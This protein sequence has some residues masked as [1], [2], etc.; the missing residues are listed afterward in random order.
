[1]LEG[2]RRNMHIEEVGPAEDIQSQTIGN[3]LYVSF[4]WGDVWESVHHIEATKKTGGG[5]IML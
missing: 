4:F 2:H 1:M 5:G 3:F